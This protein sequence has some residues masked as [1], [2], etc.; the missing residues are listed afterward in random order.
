MMSEFWTSA[1]V[2]VKDEG[3]RKPR[4]ASIT[5]AGHCL[6]NLVFRQR[7]TMMMAAGICGSIQ[8]AS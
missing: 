2:R 5:R 1:V 3:H 8:K 7:T 4:A 6:L